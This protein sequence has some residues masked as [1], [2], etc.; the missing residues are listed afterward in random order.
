MS[1]VER[2]IKPEKQ[3]ND[4]EGGSYAVRFRHSLGRPFLVKE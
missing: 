2:T 3:V 1:Q 4:Q